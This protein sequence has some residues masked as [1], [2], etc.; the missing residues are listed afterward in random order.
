[1]E[2]P[3][4]VSEADVKTPL[5]AV[6]RVIVTVSEALRSGSVMVKV[7]NRL[8]VALSLTACDATA[9]PRV[10]AVVDRGCSHLGGGISRAISRAVV[11]RQG[12]RGL[13]GARRS[14]LIRRWGKNQCLKFGGQRGGRYTTRL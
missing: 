2:K 14:D 1:M 7:E 5:A 6:S 9:P 8:S 10:G 13:Y 4:A 11:G 3:D 12:E